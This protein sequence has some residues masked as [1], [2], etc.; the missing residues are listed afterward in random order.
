QNNDTYIIKNGK[1][2]K[3]YDHK[4]KKNTIEE[5]K[6]ASI[7]LTDNY[8]LNLFDYQKNIL[9]TNMLAPSIGFNPDDGFKIGLTNTYTIKGFKR[10]PFSQQH[11]VKAGYYFATSGFDV[12]YKGEFAQIFGDWNLQVDAVVTSENFTNNF[13][14][15]GNETINDEDD[16]DLDYN[17][18]KTGIYAAKLGVVKNSDF[19]SSLGFKVLFEGYEIE[20]TPNRFITYFIPISDTEFYKHQYFGG[21]EAEFAYESVD[22][23][24]NPTRGMTFNIEAGGKTEFEDTDNTFGF[25][26][27]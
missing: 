24:I 17:R 27:T 5:N 25:L 26:N 12:R 9:R 18:V 7:K 8:Q 16:L 23:K 20:D 11:V 14:G 21:V 2:I 15:Y 22:Q 10:N 6:G 13:F 3:V 1:N 4:T 19:G